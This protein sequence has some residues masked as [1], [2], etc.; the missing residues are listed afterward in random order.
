MK[1]PISLNRLIAKD[2]EF[3]NFYQTKLKEGIRLANYS[4]TRVF[5]L[6]TPPNMTVAVSDRAGSPLQL[7][8]FS[9]VIK[10][11]SNGI[12]ISIEEYDFRINLANREYNEKKEWG[13]TPLK[14]RKKIIDFYLNCPD[15]YEVD[16]LYPIPPPVILDRYPICGLFCVDNLTYR[17]RGSEHRWNKFLDKYVAKRGS[18]DLDAINAFGLGWLEVPRRK[19]K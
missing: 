11:R 18:M 2:K 4:A 13:R 10:P 6:K 1:A 17:K 19:S 12:K 15:G 8:D 7:S 5:F 9:Y 16:Y 3:I 14:G